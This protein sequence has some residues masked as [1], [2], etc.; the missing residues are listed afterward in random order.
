MLR[1]SIRQAALGGAAVLCA[2]A[3]AP[4][5]RAEKISSRRCSARSAAAAPRAPVIRCP[6]PAKASQPCA[7]FAPQGETPAPRRHLWRRPGLLRAH[8]RRPL[9]P[10]ARAPSKKAGRHPATASA[11]RA[12]PRWS[13]AAISTAP[14]P[15][16]EN[17][18]PNCRTRSAIATRSWRDAPATARISSASP[19]SSIEDDPTLR[20][21]DLVA[22]ADGLMVAGRSADRRG[23]SLNFSP[24]PESVQR[25]LS[26]RTG[27]GEG[28][29]RPGRRHT[30]RSA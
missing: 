9:F 28:I 15:R 10:A 2:L 30:T 8:L 12:R 14:P 20:K 4:A 22:G 24:A 5:A 21:G 11:R 6:L 1:K 7:S 27:G 29:I 19:R 18:I 23:A 26:A 13:M 16:P 3:L 25:A 17:P